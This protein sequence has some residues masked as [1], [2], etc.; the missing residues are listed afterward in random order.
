MITEV[1]ESIV[2]GA[3]AEQKP[4]HFCSICKDALTL[5]LIVKVEWKNEEY[6]STPC[7]ECSVPIDFDIVLPSAI[8]AE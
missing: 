8:A 7:P 3:I 6:V 4:R 1:I 2:S 5:S